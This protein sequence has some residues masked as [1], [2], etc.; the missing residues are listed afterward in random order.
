MTHLIPNYQSF[1]YTTLFT[2]LSLLLLSHLAPSFLPSNKK[3]PKSGKKYL[4]NSTGLLLLFA[5]FKIHFFK[6]NYLLF[7]ESIW[8][9]SHIFHFMIIVRSSLWYFMSARNEGKS[10][11]LGALASKSFS[12][13]SLG[14]SL[15]EKL[16]AVTSKKQWHDPVSWLRET[17]LAFEFL[18]GKVPRQYF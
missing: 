8:V 2:D 4:D 12:E 13:W 17:K 9:I 5:F 10:F 14:Q 11:K 6:I 18:F 16:I 7:H 1:F 3:S 15:D